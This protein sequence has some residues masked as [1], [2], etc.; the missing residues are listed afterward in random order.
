MYNDLSTD[1]RALTSERNKINKIFNRCGTLSS[2][3]TF[4][5][6]YSHLCRE[7]LYDPNFESNAEQ[8][9]SFRNLLTHSYRLSHSREVELN[10]TI[11]AAE[12]LILEIVEKYKI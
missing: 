10:L 9:Y 11:Q 8:F 3:Q 7:L 5:D 4:E 1:L 2:F 6:R 12:F